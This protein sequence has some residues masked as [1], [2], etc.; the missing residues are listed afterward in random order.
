MANYCSNC[1]RF[2][3]DARTIDA[4]KQLFNH[5]DEKQTGSNRYH[6]PDFVTGGTGYM[7]DIAVG[8]D[9]ISYETRHVPNLEVLD[10]IADHYKLDYIAWYQEPMAGLYGEAVRTGGETE[11]VNI[12]TYRQKGRGNNPAF[13]KFKELQASL[14][15]NSQYPER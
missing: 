5:I 1:V 9:W 3:G 4:V 10:Q 14:L 8:A 6:M 12:D 7:E 11:W 2:I 15:L 13:V